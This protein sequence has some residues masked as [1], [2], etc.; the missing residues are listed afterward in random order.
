MMKITQENGI[1][2]VFAGPWNDNITANG[3]IGFEGPIA[4]N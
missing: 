2:T 1:P 4:A 3:I